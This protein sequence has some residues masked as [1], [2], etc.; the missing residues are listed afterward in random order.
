MNFN[1]KTILSFLTFA[2]FVVLACILNSAASNAA[3]SA[4]TFIPATAKVE[5]EK[6]KSEEKPDA[7]KL[8]T[9][10]DYLPNMPEGQKLELSWHDEFEG[11]EIDTTKWSTR[12]DYPRKGGHWMKETV[13][14]KDGKLV[15]EVINKDGKFAGGC[16]TSQGKFEQTYGYF[17]ARCKLQS[18]PGHW[19]AFWLNCKTIGSIKNGGKDGAEIDIMEKPWLT[20]K[21]QHTLHWDGY[22][23]KHHKQKAK[24]HKFKGIM[25]GYH[26]FSCLWTPDEYVFYIDGKETW[27]TKAGSVCQVPAYVLLSEEIGKWGGDIKKAKLPDAFTCD[28]VRVYKIVKTNDK[29]NSDSK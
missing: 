12:G 20:D 21:V 16:V 27:R 2:S 9:Q 29:K 6:D 25:E 15:I 23:K 10:Y 18:Q 19:S 3:S 24:I 14:I 11:D 7:S 5:A 1:K 8:D 13:K 28:Y 4:R 22:T 17:V 26:T